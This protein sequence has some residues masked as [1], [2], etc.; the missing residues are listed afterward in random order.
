MER[1]LCYNQ[2]DIPTPDE[3]ILARITKSFNYD[4]GWKNI[5]EKRKA[6]FIINYPGY[7]WGESVNFTFHF[8]VIYRLNT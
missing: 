3:V 4:R 1:G 8:I 2:W 5:L 6:E 7:V